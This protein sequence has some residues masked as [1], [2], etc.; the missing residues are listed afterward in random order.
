MSKLQPIDFE[1]YFEAVLQKLEV[2]GDIPAL[3]C[4]MAGVAQGWQD[5]G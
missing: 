3:I 4:G 5:A 2:P 1:D